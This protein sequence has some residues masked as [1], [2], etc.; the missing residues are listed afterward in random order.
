MVCTNLF[1]HELLTKKK[2]MQHLGCR[3]RVKNAIQYT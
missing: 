3:K 1:E 2:D